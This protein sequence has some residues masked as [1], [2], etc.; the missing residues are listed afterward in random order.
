MGIALRKT[1][2]RYAELGAIQLLWLLGYQLLVLKPQ[3]WFISL[4]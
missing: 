3:S 2:E 1:L 4:Y